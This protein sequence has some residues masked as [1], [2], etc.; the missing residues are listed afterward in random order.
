[1]E[2]T[3]MKMGWLL[4]WAVP[5]SWFANYVAAIFPE[6]THVFIEPGP[7]SGE[8]L[9][10]AG[11]FDA[12]TGYSLGAQLMLENPE[13]VSRLSTKIGLLAPIFAFAQEM[14]LGG[15]IPHTQVKYLSRWLRRDRAAALTDFYQRAGLGIPT[16]LSSDISLETLEWGLHRLEIGAVLPPA[17]SGWKLLCG[18]A[19]ALLDGE[20]LARLDPA[21]RLVS[22]ATHHPEIL[23][24]AWAKELQK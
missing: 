17:P 14:N 16:A 23:L 10:K 1:M 9:E 3:P 22:G 21:V 6:A 18:A 20:Q 5:S 7:E 15:K 19:D 4:G 12:L 2:T 8:R 11:P 13:R 24:H